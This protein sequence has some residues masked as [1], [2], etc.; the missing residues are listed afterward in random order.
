MKC[1]EGVPS[2]VAG[3]NDQVWIAQASAEPIDN[4]IRAA[5]GW[6]MGLPP[7]TVHAAPEWLLAGSHALVVK[8][9]ALPR[10]HPMVDMPRPL[11][12]AP[13]T[14]PVQPPMGHQVL[15]PVIERSFAALLAAARLF[16]HYTAYFGV[17]YDGNTAQVTQSGGMTWQ[18]PWPI[19]DAGTCDAL[20]AGTLDTARGICRGLA[21]CEGRHRRPLFAL[22]TFYRGLLER[23]WRIRMILMVVALEAL[24]GTGG[25]ELKHQVCERAASFTAPRRED[26][27]EAYTR[28]KDLYSLRS[29][30]VHGG[31][32]GPVRGKREHAL[33]Q[34]GFLEYAVRTTLRQVLVDEELAKRFCGKPDD[35]NEFL[36]KRV[37]ETAE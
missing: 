28:L 19:D 27:F 9:E 18:T 21:A 6:L 36:E 15:H 5:Q 25:Q 32:S 14:N 13:P 29:D 33:S 31:F 26:R 24:F 1:E 8:G 37:F 3:L 17:K 4:W 12:P 2:G 35:L 30:L 10:M 23:D 20:S 16:L 34:L 22:D 11:V 7:E